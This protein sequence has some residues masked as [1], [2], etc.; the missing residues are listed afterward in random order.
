MVVVNRNIH[1]GNAPRQIEDPIDLPP[2]P[3]TEPLISE[4]PSPFEQACMSIPLM[5][6][7]VTTAMKARRRRL[8]SIHIGRQIAVR[9]YS[10]KAA[11]GDNPRRLAVAFTLSD[12]IRSVCN[13]P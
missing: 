11:W 7:I 13:W 8:R 4:L 3:L 5:R 6:G 2:K 1:R 12:A 10:T 9:R